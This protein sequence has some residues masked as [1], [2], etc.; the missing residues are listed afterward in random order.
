MT[1]GGGAPTANDHS[2][3][4]HDVGREAGWLGAESVVLGGGQM[5]FR[6]GEI[7]E[8]AESDEEEEASLSVVVGPRAHGPT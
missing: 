2:R 6:G 8:S 5:C 3:L 4:A 1:G 7:S